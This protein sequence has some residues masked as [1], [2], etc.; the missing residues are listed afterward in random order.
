MNIY[1]F[2]PHILR[3]Y[4]FLWIFKAWSGIQIEHLERQQS[5]DV[6]TGPGPRGMFTEG[7]IHVIN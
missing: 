3:E 7:L 4:N 2:Q 6:Y 1:N 5:Q